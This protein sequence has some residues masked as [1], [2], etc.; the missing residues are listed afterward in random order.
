MLAELI[1][2]LHWREGRTSNNSPFS[3]PFLPS[4]FTFVTEKPDLAQYIKVHP[5][6][7]LFQCHF[8][9]VNEER[10][11]QVIDKGF[12]L[13][14]V[15]LFVCRVYSDR[16][17]FANECKVKYTEIFAKLI[18]EVFK[19]WDAQPQ[20]E[21]KGRLGG[22]Q[23]RQR[24][25]IRRNCTI[26]DKNLNLLWLIIEWN[27]NTQTWY[28]YFLICIPYAFWGNHLWINVHKCA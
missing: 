23:V 14:F 18:S 4:I 16:Q 26:W 24:Y 5:R 15:C 3:L 28:A 1:A 9:K 11:D 22:R 19:L 2:R 20:G 13:H 10:E 21:L 8:I 7:C 27:L 25:C 17:Y 12:I 6:L